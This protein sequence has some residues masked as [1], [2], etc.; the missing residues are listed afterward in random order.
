[1]RTHFDQPKSIL[2]LKAKAKNLLD[3]I[4][5]DEGS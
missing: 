3:G 4:L 5:I 1:M 2:I